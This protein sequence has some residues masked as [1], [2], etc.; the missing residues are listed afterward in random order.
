MPNDQIIARDTAN[1]MAGRIVAARTTQTALETRERGFEGVAIDFPA[2]PDTLELN[3]STDYAVLSNVVAPDGIHQYRSTKP[4]EIP[5]SF[6]LHALDKVYCP[7]GAL[8]LLQVAS[9]L[10]AFTLPLA[11]DNGRVLVSPAVTETKSGQG[12]DVT[13]EK[14]AD[15]EPVFALSKASATSGLFNPVTCWLHLIWIAENQ[16]G[17]SCIGYVRDVTVKL[18]GPWLRGPAGS[19][20]LPT[21]ADFGFTFVHRPGHG[22]DYSNGQGFTRSGLSSEVDSE[23]QAYGGTVKENLFNTRDLVNLANYRGFN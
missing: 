18:N 2:M 17:I 4:L 3:R 6:S 13:L 14:T 19:F 1:R 16:P 8:T 21:S 11:K 20:N 5:F 23:P 22:N 10:H 12:S 15:N 9:R 7:Q